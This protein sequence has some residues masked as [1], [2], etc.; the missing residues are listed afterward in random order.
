MKDFDTVFDEA[1]SDRVTTRLRVTQLGGQTRR[2][3]GKEWQWFC[4]CG[5]EKDCPCKNPILI[6]VGDILDR[7][8]TG[9]RTEEGDEII[10]IV[11][12]RDAEVLHQRIVAS[13]VS[14]VAANPDFGNGGDDDDIPGVLYGKKLDAV[15][16]AF[17]LGWKIGKFLD[18]STDGA[19]SDKLADLIDKVVKEIKETKD[20]L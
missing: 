6:T 4:L 12:P 7:I 17:K 10:D 5:W 11:L 1:L 15:I 13:T 16:G 8:G 3:L 18:D 19:I 9:E 20:K 2:I 14:D